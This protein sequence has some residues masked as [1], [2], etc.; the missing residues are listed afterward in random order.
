VSTATH[1][2][3]QTRLSEELERALVCPACRHSLEVESEHCRCVQCGAEYP[4]CDGVAVLINELNSLFMISGVL[5]AKQNLFAPPASAWRRALS[6]CMPVLSQNICGRHCYT[7]VAEELLRLTPK[8]RVLV[9][10]SCVLGSGM[11]VLLDNPNIQVV[12]SDVELGSRAAVVFDAH[13]IPFEDDS[14]DGVIVQAVLEHVIDPQRVVSEL[15][16]VLRAG[17]IVYA[18]TPFMQQVHMGAYDF[19]RFTHS[20]HRR[21]FRHF[22]EVESGIAC[23]PGMALAWSWQYFLMSFARKQTGRTLAKAI[24]RLTA[25]PLKYFDRFLARR[26]AAYDAASG[27]YFIGRKADHPIDDRQLVS[28]YRGAV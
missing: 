25:F 7:R 28:E 9:I 12:E 3:G 13:D 11:E 21:L 4:I 18:E 27:F 26:P 16:R 19:T 8:P 15:Q 5:R 10:G 24:A 1:A 17:G 2:E 6:Q 22:D 20:G 23:G 14:F